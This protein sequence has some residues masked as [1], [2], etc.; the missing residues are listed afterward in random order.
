MTSLCY[1]VHKEIDHS[2]EIMTV[3]EVRGQRP[4]AAVA[5]FFESSLGG[6]STVSAIP[7][8]EKEEDDMAPSAATKNK[9]MDCLMESIL[10]TESEPTSEGRKTSAATPSP[11]PTP[12][13]PPPPSLPP[14]APSPCLLACCDASDTSHRLTMRSPPP[15]ARLFAERH[16]GEGRR[17]QMVPPAIELT[18]SR[19][20]AD[21]AP[22]S[23]TD[24]AR[25][26]SGVHQ[27]HL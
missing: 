5:A 25:R 14:W 12:S 24:R 2:E 9:N 15:V 21:G 23:P 1:C 4:K 20:G 22:K 18:S 17:Y 7:N 13:Q 11:S 10:P 27:R 16:G 8:E 26:A 3:V 6:A 19:T